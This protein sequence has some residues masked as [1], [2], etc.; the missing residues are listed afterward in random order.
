MATLLTSATFVHFLFHIL[1]NE[2]IKAGALRDQIVTISVH[3][4]RHWTYFQRIHQNVVETGDFN[5]WVR[6]FAAGVIEQCHNQLN[7]VKQLE[8]LRDKN[9][10]KTSDRRRDGV[11]R[12]VS[13]LAGCQL[14]T[15]ALAAE[16]CGISVKYARELLC[17]AEGLDMVEEVG[18]RKRNKVY[19]VKE[20]RRLLE[21]SMGM[22]PAADRIV[23]DTTDGS[24]R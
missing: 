9:M 23:H 4:D 21:R 14:I 6:F 8:Q 22:V 13:N 17:Y 10:A 16:R 7:L 19:E 3:I 1:S 18:N 24:V 12:F 2:L 5:E 11:T 15:A 20:V